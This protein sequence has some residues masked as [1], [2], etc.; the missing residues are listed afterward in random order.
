MIYDEI[1][2]IFESKETRPANDLPI[3]MPG[4]SYIE[5]EYCQKTQMYQDGKVVSKPNMSATLDKSSIVA[6]TE[7]AILS[8]LPN[9]CRVRITLGGKTKTYRVTDNSLKFSLDTPGTYTIS[10][11]SKYTLDAEY[12]IE[13]T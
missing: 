8:G 13:A 5:G 10:C 7:Y 11:S 2:G 12:S 3:V 9:E 1:S 4:K 6:G